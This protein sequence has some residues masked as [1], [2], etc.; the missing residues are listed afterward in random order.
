MESNLE[1]W[2]PTADCGYKVS[3][4]G[5][6]LSLTRFVPC[7]PPPGKRKVGGVLLSAFINKG[8]GYLQVVLSD[9]K[10]TSVHRLVAVAFCK[11]Y[12]DGMVVNHKN[13]VKTDNRASNLEWV[14]QSENH[15]HS[16]IKLRRKGSGY[17]KFGADHQ[18]SKAIVMTS[19]KDG[20]SEIF[21]C[22]LDAIRTYLFL[23]SSGISRCCNGKS[24]SHKGYT[25][26]FAA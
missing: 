1:H 9:R 26:R 2:M 16:Y 22:A 12:A 24:N 25:F 20:S 21:G 6:V 3:N 17:G 13:G 5:R 18:T 11:G 8:N 4:M 15:I 14:T 10:Q 19:I 7:G 23:E